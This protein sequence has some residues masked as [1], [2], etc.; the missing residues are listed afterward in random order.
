MGAALAEHGGVVVGPVLV[1]VWGGREGSAG[2]VGIMVD[3]GGD[4]GEFGEEG[5]GVI[6][7]GF[8]V[9]CFVQTAGVH[10]REGGGVVEGR[11]GAGELRHGVEVFGEGI[12]HAYDEWREGGLLGELAG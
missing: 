9:L 2:G 8:P 6:K 3:L 10:A 12:E 11:D 7:G 1:G 4:G 5:D